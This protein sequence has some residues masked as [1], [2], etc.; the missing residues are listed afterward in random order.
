[1]RSDS[2]LSIP[3]IVF[4]ICCIISIPSFFDVYRLLAFNTF[5]RDDYAPFLLRF[6][7]AHGA[8]PGS[9]F[10]Y[11]VLSVLPAVPFYWALPLY[12]FSLLPKIDASYLRAVQALAF[13]HFLS[14]AGAATSLLRLFRLKIGG[15]MGEAG[16]DCRPYNNIFRIPCKTGIE[17]FDVLVIFVLLYYWSGP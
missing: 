6:T 17:S 16:L 7:S 10:G 2:K 8:W 15:S 12:R 14:V 11:R 4:F 1:M 13:L 3:I 5:P 9:P